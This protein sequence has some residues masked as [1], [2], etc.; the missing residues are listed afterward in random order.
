MLHLF[1]HLGIYPIASLRPKYKTL[2]APIP[3]IPIPGVN[4]YP[5]GLGPRGDPEGASATLEYYNSFGTSNYGLLEN[6]NTRTLYDK[7][8]DQTLHISSQLARHQAD[9]RGFYDR[10]SQ[11]TE[12]LKH[13]LDNLDVSKLAQA[14]E[15]AAKAKTI[16][17]ADEQGSGKLQKS[18]S[19][20]K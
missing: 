4:D 20:G 18:R 1:F 11:Q 14:T 19:K 15:K 3:S 9:L 12:G 13:L 6:F 8:E 7:I 2:G 10:I 17:E 16:G 5:D